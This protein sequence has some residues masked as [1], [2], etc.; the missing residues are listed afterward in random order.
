MRSAT[1]SNVR[2][3]QR[4]T[5]GGVYKPGGTDVA[6]LKK[7]DKSKASQAARKRSKKRSAASKAAMERAQK[8][9]ASSKKSISD[10]RKAYEKEGGTWASGGRNKGGLMKKGNK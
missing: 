3:A 5:K 2:Q 10:L 6:L 9:G 7:D 4:D 1:R 8:S